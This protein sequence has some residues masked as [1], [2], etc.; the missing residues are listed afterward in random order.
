MNVGQIFGVIAS[1]G[2][3]VAV[4]VGIISFAHTMSKDKEDREKQRKKEW[5]ERERARNEENK[6]REEEIAAH[7]KEW[8]QLNDTIGQMQSK[9][10]SIDHTIGNGFAGSIKEQIKDLKENCTCKMV[11]LEKQV[12]MDTPRIKELEDRMNGL[13]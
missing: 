6:K 1:I 13:K 12:A 7:I 5:E 4:V 8:T 11:G 3:L 9:I 10:T 2:S